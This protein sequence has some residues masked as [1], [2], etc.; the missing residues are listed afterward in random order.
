MRTYPGRVSEILLN[1]DGSRSALIDYPERA[2]PAPGRYLLAQDRESILRTP[3]FQAGARSRGFLAASPVPESWYPG[4]ALELRGPFGHG[5][6]L[7]A[8]VRRLAG[9]A[10]GTS[11]ER[12]L[13]L[14][15]EALE[16]GAAVTLFG[17]IVSSG[18]PSSVEVYPSGAF[19]EAQGWA[20]HLV[21]DAL[22]ERLP[23][24]WEMAGRQRAGFPC[25]GQALVFAQMPCGGL[26]DCGACAVQSRGSWKLACKDGPVFRLKDLE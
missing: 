6:Q 26:A 5:F 25:P 18:L 4:M 3:L 2:A 24:L 7:P 11:G 22:M 20:D 23:V 1:P 19:S 10:V 9:I 13:P 17:D 21:V 14:V 8:N 15:R 16:K 12:L